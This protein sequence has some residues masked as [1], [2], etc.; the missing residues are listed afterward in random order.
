MSDVAVRGAVV[1]Y[2]QRTALDGVDLD[3]GSGEMVA[4]LGPSGCGKSTLLRAIAGLVPLDAGS[5][6]IDGEDMAGVPTHRRRV[7][8]MFADHALFPHLDVAG[9]VGFGLRIAG[10]DR[11]RLNRRVG[12]MLELVGLADRADSAVQELSR[13]QQ[14]R[15]ALARTLAPEPRLVMLDE[16]MSS[17]DRVLRRELN[18]TV[19]AALEQAGA[20]ALLVTHDR[21]EAF[22]MSGRVGVMRSGRIEQIDTAERLL[23]TPANGWVADFLADPSA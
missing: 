5:V 3:V 22:A 14:Q 2:G 13:G 9:N 20:T 10:W 16:P 23:A 1:R 11:Q 19:S 21:D 17:L 15:V 7:G 8:L 18:R 6:R 12:E 4:I